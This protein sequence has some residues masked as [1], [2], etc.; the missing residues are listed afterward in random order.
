MADCTY[1]VPDLAVSGD[2][3]YGQW[4]CDQAYIDF[5]WH[6]YGFTNKYWQGGWGFDDCCN[7]RKPLAR[8]FNA[9]Y[10]LDYSA[11]DWQNED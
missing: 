1:T 11:V 5:F 8:T 10:L 9:M 3:H 2:E 4:I 7:I 6:S